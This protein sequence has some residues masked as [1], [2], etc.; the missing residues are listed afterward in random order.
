MATSTIQATLQS[1]LS[2]TETFGAGVNGQNT[3]TFAPTN[4][5]VVLNAGTTPP[6][7]L[8]APVT[9]ALTAG[10]ATLD[11]TNLPGITAGEIVNATGL[12]AQLVKFENPLTNA[13][14]ITVRA[15]AATPY[16]LLGAAWT[17]TLAPGQSAGPF[18]LA[19]AA[20]VV[21][22]GAKNI[23]LV[24]TGTQSLIAHFVFG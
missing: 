11:L 3:A 1:Y 15:G 12:K 23:D 20:P 14:S 19:G 5:L 21:G 10:A 22:A 6:V 16:L 24:G 17:L 13:N 7:S 8:H 18:N 2:V 4:E 9:Q